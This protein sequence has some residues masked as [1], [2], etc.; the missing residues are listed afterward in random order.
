MESRLTSKKSSF[1]LRAIS[2]D[3][4]D[5]A[6]IIPVRIKVIIFRWGLEREKIFLKNLEKLLEILSWV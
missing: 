4:I 2:E 6:E 1:N 5:S 3:T